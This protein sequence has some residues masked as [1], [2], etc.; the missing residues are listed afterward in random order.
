MIKSVCMLTLEIC[1]APVPALYANFF[2]FQ[3]D[4]VIMPQS[5]LDLL[6]ILKACTHISIIWDLCWFLE[7]DRTSALKLSNF[8]ILL[9]LRTTLSSKPR[10]ALDQDTLRRSS[11]GTTVVLSPAFQ[12]RPLGAKRNLP[13]SGRM[14]QWMASKSVC[15][16]SDMRI[17]WNRCCLC[18]RRYLIWR[19]HFVTRLRRT[20][21]VFEQTATL[22]AHNKLVTFWRS[23]S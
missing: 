10:A 22:F 14:P 17:K 19:E 15:R 7:N 23:V 13:W 6:E 1:L 3:L 5:I 20:R 12:P 16:F 11:A 18:S 8:K 2:G 9:S 4:L 21:Y